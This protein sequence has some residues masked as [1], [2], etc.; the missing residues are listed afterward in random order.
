MHVKKATILLSV[1][2][3]ILLLG[4]TVLV[5]GPVHKEALPPLYLANISAAASVAAVDARRL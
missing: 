3:I 5:A 4:T 1:I 2:L